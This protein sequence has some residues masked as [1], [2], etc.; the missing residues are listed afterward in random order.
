MINSLGFLLTA[1]FDNNNPAT[2]TAP[3]T[4]KGAKIVPTDLFTFLPFCPARPGLEIRFAAIKR[5]FYAIAISINYE[6]SHML[7]TTPSRWDKSAAQ[8]R[9]LLRIGN[10]VALTSS[11]ACD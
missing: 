8:R 4:T 9:E 2:P 7:P 1:S 5:R 11:L 6:A 3:R 10:N